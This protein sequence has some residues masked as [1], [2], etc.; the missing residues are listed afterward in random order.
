MTLRSFAKEHRVFNCLRDDGKSLRNVEARDH[1]DS[2]PGFPPVSWD[3]PGKLTQIDAE[4]SLLNAQSVNH[5]C[6]KLYCE[7]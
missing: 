2:Y 7:K 6:K 4:M 5:C 1:G 3:K